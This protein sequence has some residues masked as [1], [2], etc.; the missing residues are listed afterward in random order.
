MVVVVGV[1]VVEVVVVEVV[2]LEVVVDVGEVVV[3]VPPPQRPPRPWPPWCER[4]LSATA[5][6][7]TLP[8]EA[9]AATASEAA[10]VA[11]V[12]RSAPP[13]QARERER[14]LNWLVIVLLMR[15]SS[16]SVTL[17]PLCALRSISL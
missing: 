6:V 16:S 7:V 1:V 9:G 4:G 13:T 15:S 8:A 2:V 5:L 14:T 17:P 3:V 10:T 12:A 11:S